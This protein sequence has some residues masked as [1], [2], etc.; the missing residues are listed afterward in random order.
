MERGENKKIR[1]IKSEDV[2]ANG[3]QGAKENE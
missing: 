2:R 1:I 3:K